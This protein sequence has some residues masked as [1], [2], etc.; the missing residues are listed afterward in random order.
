ML[1]SLGYSIKQAA[2]QIFRNRTMSFASLFSITA[3]MLIL[4]LFFVLIVNVGVAMETAKMGYDTVSVYLADDVTYTS[5]NQMADELRAMP[6]VSE[7]TYLDK[8]TAL[9]QWKVQYWGENAYLLDS[10]PEN[11]LPNSVEVKL[12]D[13]SGAD[14]VVAKVKTFQGIED[15]KY[16]QETVEKLV[17]I[18]DSLKLAMLIIMLFLV[19]VSIIVVSNTIKLTVFARQKE[20]E[21]MKYVGATNWF[22]RGP[23]LVE[24]IFIGIIA[25][26]ISVGITALIYEKLMGLLGTDMSLMIGSPMVSAGFLVANLVW[27][28]LALGI[29]IGACGSIISMRRFLDT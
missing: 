3:M 29:S 24:G 18:T 8:D 27:V 14:A 23:F 11:P 17:K 1:G 20:I 13:L 9:A 7:A 12:K 6:E 21:I 22:I 5:A 25:A 19:I 28:F 4:G 15:I 10:L 26:G 16:Y 2:V